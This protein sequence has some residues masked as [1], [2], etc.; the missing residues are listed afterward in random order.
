M[1]ARRPMWAAPGCKLGPSGPPREARGLGWKGRTPKH[2]TGLVH[3]GLKTSFTSEGGEENRASLSTTSWMLAAS[4]ARTSGM[5]C[6]GLKT[7]FTSERVVRKTVRLIG[8]ASG[9]LGAE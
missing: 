7:S 8:A 4:D 1:L 9:V 3:A 2:P 6:A 5:G